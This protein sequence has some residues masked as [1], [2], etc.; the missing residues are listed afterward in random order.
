MLLLSLLNALFFIQRLADGTQF[1]WAFL[2][3]L[4]LLAVPIIFNA[5]PEPRPTVWAKYFF[6]FF[7]PL[8][9]FLLLLIRSRLN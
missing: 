9:I 3:N 5:R 4:S 6:Y 1:A 2:Q 7:Y 8:H